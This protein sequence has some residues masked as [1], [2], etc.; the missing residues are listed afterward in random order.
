LQ[1]EIKGYD[2]DFQKIVYEQAALESN[3][4]WFMICKLDY[5]DEYWI[6]LYYDNLN[7]APNGDD[8]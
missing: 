3:S 2:L 5:S 4:V 1:P 6:A 7:N 8:L